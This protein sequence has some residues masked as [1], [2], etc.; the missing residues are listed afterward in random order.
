MIASLSEESKVGQVEMGQPA[1]ETAVNLT[2]SDNSTADP[3]WPDWL[4]LGKNATEEDKAVALVNHLQSIGHRIRIKDEALVVSNGATL[5]EEFWALLRA[6]RD[7]TYAFLSDKESEEKQSQVL[8]VV[9]TSLRNSA[10]LPVGSRLKVVFEQEL[11]SCDP[12]SYS[13]FSILLIL[14]DLIPARKLL[15]GLIDAL[16]ADDGTPTTG[17]TIL[18]F[19]WDI[20][21][22]KS[23]E[24]RRIRGDF[25]EDDKLPSR[26]KRAFAAR[27]IEENRKSGIGMITMYLHKAVA[28]YHAKEKQRLAPISGD[29]VPP[30]YL[31]NG[32]FERGKPLV[33]A[34][35]V[36]AGKTQVAT[37]LGVALA[38]GRDFLGYTVP[39]PLTVAM[40]SGESGD[41]T[42]ATYRRNAGNPPLA[43]LRLYPHLPSI[44]ALASILQD[45]PADVVILDPMYMLLDGEQASNL[46]V[47]GRQL[48]E[49]ASIVEEQRPGAT[50][51]L[52]HHFQETIKPG[53]IPTLDHL[54]FAGIKQFA[55]QWLLV[56]RRIPYRPGPDNLWL[57]AGGAADKSDLVGLDHT[58]DPWTWTV[59]AKEAADLQDAGTRDDRKGDKKDTTRQSRETKVLGALTSGP[60]RNVDLKKATKLDGTV[61][62]EILSGLAGTVAKDD[63][64]LYSLVQK[65][66]GTHR[67]VKG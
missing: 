39:R 19:D 10:G 34:G 46:F 31:V 6:H 32:L 17:A 23:Q 21:V 50:L 64:G 36:K 27:I 9:R 4:E 22:E 63:E 16:I 58:A 2:A 30:D 48:K 45:E 43:A 13:I 61:L 5:T 57:L 54:A 12:D 29:P 53:V 66:A 65:D 55:R 37:E 7:A 67:R 11:V 62:K 40:F 8:R 26:N 25:L 20:V 15:P 18:G 14:L 1:A 47:M 59:L 51:V 44:P 41:S 3:P 33:I 52:V 35:P 49:L 24:W 60:L 56:N 28:L 42:L 38:T